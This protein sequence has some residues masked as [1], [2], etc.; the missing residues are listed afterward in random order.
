MLFINYNFVACPSYHG[1]TL[2]SCLLNNHP[3]VTALGDTI[4]AKKF[5]EGDTLCGCGESISKCEFWQYVFNEM[6]P[7]RIYRDGHILPVYPVVFAN[8]N[9][10]RQMFRIL[11]YL[12]IYYGINLW[13]IFKKQLNVFFNIYNKYYNIIT[14]YQNTKYFIDGQKN[15]IKMMVLKNRAE[16][17]KKIKILHILRDPR[18][19]YFSYMRRGRNITTY[20]FT[21]TWTNYH[22]RMMK[23]KE[24]F[25]P[26]KVMML[27]Y[28]K[29][30]E[31][32]ERYTKMI[33][34]FYEMPENELLTSNN[35]DDRK[36]VIG[37]KMIANFDGMVTLDT[38]WVDSMNPEEKREIVRL[39]EPLFSQVGYTE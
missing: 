17:K 13:S 4:P 5:V 38:R 23:L 35:Y 8:E 11:G 32:P 6:N 19:V 25:G 1:A 39:T 18:A 31:E 22:K 9:A 7:N 10:N 29:L 33:Q 36:H 15:I 14:E 16:E 3:L 26:E 27:Q 24:R 30:C 28:E 12:D 20:R 21:K 2:I 34:E 37:N